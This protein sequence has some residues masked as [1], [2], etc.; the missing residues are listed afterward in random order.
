MIDVFSESWYRWE[1]RVID[2]RI[3]H[4]CVFTCVTTASCCTMAHVL[5]NYAQLNCPD[6]LTNKQNPELHIACVT[7]S[8]QHERRL[9]PSRS[10]VRYDYTQKLGTP[11]F[12][13]AS[14]PQNRTHL[15]VKLVA[16]VWSYFFSASP[17]K[18]TTSFAHAFIFVFC[19]QYSLPEKTLQ[20]VQMNSVV[21]ST[22][23]VLP[24]QVLILVQSYN[25]QYITQESIE[26]NV[27]FSV[28]ESTLPCT[29]FVSSSVHLN[30]I[31]IEKRLA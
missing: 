8:G 19:L 31:I 1:T 16:L 5:P 11:Y 3:F 17:R 14:P 20:G 9:A 25:Y 24:S 22:A 10:A 2:L 12:P 23:T 6:F 21:S 29:P 15:T 27:K 26:S 28:S 13:S 30:T 4:T 7:L 18:D